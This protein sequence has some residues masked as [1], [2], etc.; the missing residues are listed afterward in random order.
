[1]SKAPKTGLT[2]KHWFGYMFGDW[3]GCMTFALMAS[4]FSIYCTNVLGVNASL[5]GVLTIIWTIWDAIN[6]PMMGA[7]MDKAFIKKQN[8]NGKFR[9]WLLRATPLLAVTAIALWTVPTFLE[10]I[11]LLVALFSFKILYEASYTMFNIPMG[12]LLSAMSTNDAERASL[13]SARGVGSMIGNMLPGM[14][15]PVIIGIFGENTSTGYMI[16]GTACAIVGFVICLLH[17][18][19]TEER[20]VVN[21]EAKADDIKISDILTVVKKNRA[22]VALCIHGV[23]ICT[24]QYLAENISMYMYSAV[25]NDVTYKTLASALSAPFMVG[26]MVFVPFMC[27]KMGLEKVIRVTLLIGGAICVGLFGLHLVM[28]VGPL[29]HGVILGIGSGFAMVSIQMQWGLVGEAIDYN[30]YITGKRTEG[31]IYGTFNLSRRIGQT[32]GLGISFF[33][34]DWIGYA[35]KLEL[36]SAST[37]F[38]FKILCVLVPAVFILGSWAAFKFVWNITPEIRAKMAQQKASAEAAPEISE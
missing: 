1:M 24:M 14:V 26:A 10:G 2:K 33:A 6:D 38:G 32:V 28:N 18:A 5:M 37:I 9:P 19:L 25:Y 29:L 16:T 12:S 30:E 23:C 8:K 31:S 4:T 15:G 36:Q 27:K 22:F 20:V 35:P 13:S 7:L 3:G 11:P 17:Y 34:L 21:E